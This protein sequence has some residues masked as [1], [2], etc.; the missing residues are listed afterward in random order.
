MEH[1]GP[2]P[3][4]K[5]PLHPEGPPCSRYPE[6][7]L[8]Q[9]PHHCGQTDRKATDGYD[10]AHLDYST[11][12]GNISRKVLRALREAFIRRRKAPQQGWYNDH[13]DNATAAPGTQ[14][15][16]NSDEGILPTL[17]H[18]FRDYLTGEKTRLRLIPNRLHQMQAVP[19]RKYRVLQGLFM[20][21]V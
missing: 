13:H 1:R 7:H 8:D 4:E 15:R 18:H 5:Y 3:E 21:V 20:W 12:S 16:R 9:C 19:E 11:K 14:P 17:C 6:A 2:P 10:Q